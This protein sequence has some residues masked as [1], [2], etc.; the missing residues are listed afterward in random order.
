MGMAE[1]E[2]TLCNRWIL[3]LNVVAICN[4]HTRRYALSFI[5]FT[6]AS[7]FH[8][9]P[10]FKGSLNFTD[11]SMYSALKATSR[12]SSQSEKSQSAAREAQSQ[13]L[14]YGEYPVATNTRIFTLYEGR[15]QWPFEYNMQT[16]AVSKWI[17]LTPIGLYIMTSSQSQSS[18]LCST[19]KTPSR[20]CK[21]QY[22]PHN[23]LLPTRYHYPFDS[24]KP[25]GTS[26]L[27]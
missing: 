14:I 3:C 5:F 11:Y 21:L 15:H 4:T 18:K 8:T 9:R 16:R 20:C 1:K 12:F 24:N 17:C 6:S 26:A 27:R 2:L 25:R 23:P 10:S 19:A 13:K 7:V 22:I